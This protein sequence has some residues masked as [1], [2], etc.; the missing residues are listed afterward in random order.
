MDWRGAINIVGACSIAAMA[1]LV[2]VSRRTISLGRWSVRLTAADAG[3][4]AVFPFLAGLVCGAGN[5][6]LLASTGYWTPGDFRASP[7]F[8]ALNVVLIVAVVPVLAATAVWF[9]LRRRRR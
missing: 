1:V 3:L 8:I 7:W 5:Y 2:V 9:G 6:I 4:L